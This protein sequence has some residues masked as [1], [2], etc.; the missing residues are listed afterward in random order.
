MPDRP[1][2]C[3]ILERRMQVAAQPSSPRED[4]AGD[5]RVRD[6]PRSKSIS[7]LTDHR[8]TEEDEAFA[9]YAVFLAQ[10]WGDRQLTRVRAGVR[11]RVQSSKAP[12]EPQKKGLVGLR[13]RRFGSPTGVS[14]I[15]RGSKGGPMGVREGF[16]CRRAE[17]R[18]GPLAPVVPVLAIYVKTTRDSPGGPGRPTVG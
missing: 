1:A 4:P 15:S 6:P 5:E 12:N 18:N 9:Q 7:L 2:A 8:T 3:S 13:A 17:T 16:M 10:P 11:R 14:A